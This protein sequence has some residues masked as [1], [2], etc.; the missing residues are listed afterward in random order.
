LNRRDESV[1]RHLLVGVGIHR[2]LRGVGRDTRRRC[3]L[4]QQ[5]ALQIGLQH[6]VVVLGGTQIKI[7]RHGSLLRLRIAKLDKHSVGLDGAA[8]QHDDALDGAVR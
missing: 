4:R 6:F 3:A 5:V 2:R 1:L 8:G 7:R